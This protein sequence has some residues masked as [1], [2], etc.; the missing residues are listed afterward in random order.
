MAKSGTFAFPPALLR[1]A[2]SPS[3]RSAPGRSRRP[4]RPGSNSPPFQSTHCRA[5]QFAV[6][7]AL[8][9]IFTLIELRFAFSKRERDF[10]LPIFP[11]ER[12]RHQGLAA[13]RA[14]ADQLADLR[15]VQEELARCLGRV[16]L[17]SEEH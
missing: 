11:I 10:H 5:F 15:F 13:N 16:I 17:R 8:L 4:P 2:W 1:R 14:F 9:D 7:L 12:Q 6:G 3:P